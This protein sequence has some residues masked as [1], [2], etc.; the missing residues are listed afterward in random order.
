[1]KTFILALLVLAPCLAFAEC[2]VVDYVDRTEVV[3]L[4]DESKIA[5]ATEYVPTPNPKPTDEYISR[6]KK[7]EV[8]PAKPIQRKIGH[9]YIGMNKKEFKTAWGKKPWKIN[10]TITQYSTKEQWVL[11]ENRRQY[12]YFTDDILTAI[13]D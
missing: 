2:R 5:P 10:R 6:E 12:A 7:T 1:M 8:I 3:C 13:Q 11:E 4:P 9:I